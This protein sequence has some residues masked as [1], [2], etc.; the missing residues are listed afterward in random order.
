MCYLPNKK[1]YKSSHITLDKVTYE[2][3]LK[4]FS[5]TFVELPKF[6]KTIEEAKNHIEDIWFYFLSMVMRQMSLLQIC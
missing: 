2:H 3:D 1:A 5:Y 6:N 4:D